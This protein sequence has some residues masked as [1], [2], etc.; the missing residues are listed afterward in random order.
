MLADLMQARVGP[1]ATL[2]ELRECR[3]LLDRARQIHS[4]PLIRTELLVVKANEAALGYELGEQPN[5][6][7]LQ[8]RFVAE[9]EAIAASRR[10]Q[11]TLRNA[12]F[13]RGVTVDTCL[14]SGDLERAAPLLRKNIDE[15]EA[16][17]ADD[18]TDYQNHEDLVESLVLET[19]LQ[20]LAQDYEAA[21]RAGN[22][23]IER[24]RENLARAPRSANALVSL[25]ILLCCVAEC[26]RELDALLESGQNLTEAR[27][28]LEQ[29]VDEDREFLAARVALARV[30]VG[31]AQTHRGQASGATDTTRGLQT[32]SQWYQRALE[33]IDDL[34]DGALASARVAPEQVERELATCRAALAPSDAPSS[35]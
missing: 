6:P 10:D 5:A 22:A 15:L 34:P 33:E 21:L 25:G 14:K 19:H 26:Q 17:I 16:L 7:E 27:T 4:T 8:S 35:D 30:Y 13:V 29:A 3:A 2:R 11:N 12:R 28:L 18:P 23:G 31:L 24:A 9:V 20:L 32:A 1:E